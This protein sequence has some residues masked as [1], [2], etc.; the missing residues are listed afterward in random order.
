MLE[1]L[2]VK[3]GRC[4]RCPSNMDENLLEKLKAWR[5]AR[6]R[7]LKVPAFVVFQTPPSAVPIYA[8]WL[9]VGSEA[10]EVTRPDQGGFPL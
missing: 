6:S 2:E 3:L 7:E 9:L 4:G 1:T 8:I 5:G 10:M